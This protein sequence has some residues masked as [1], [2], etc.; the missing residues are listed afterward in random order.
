MLSYYP[1]GIDLMDL[2]QYNF[3]DAEIIEYVR[4]I[5]DK[6]LQLTDGDLAICY[7]DGKFRVKRVRLEPDE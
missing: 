4:V 1:G 3:K 5:I 2:V 7:L 6:S